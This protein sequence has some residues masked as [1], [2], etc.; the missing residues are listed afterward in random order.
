MCES[1]NSVVPL[2]PERISTVPVKALEATFAFIMQRALKAA[3]NK[4]QHSHANFIA[5]RQNFSIQNNANVASN[6][7]TG[8]VIQSD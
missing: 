3:K 5:V 2:N 7:F 4:F 1:L 8:T 6:A